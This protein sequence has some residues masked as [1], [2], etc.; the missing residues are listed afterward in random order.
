MVHRQLSFFR[1]FNCCSVVI[2]LHLLFHFSNV[3]F[4]MWKCVENWRHTD[5]EWMDL[6]ICVLLFVVYLPVM[7]LLVVVCVPMVWSVAHRQLR[8]QANRI[9]SFGERYSIYAWIPVII[10]R[11]SVHFENFEKSGICAKTRVDNWFSFFVFLSHFWCWRCCV[12][13]ATLTVIISPMINGAI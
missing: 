9:Q 3:K 8:L 13:A 4:P 10:S 1:L 2:V 12:C 11:I 5:Y 7:V 6:C